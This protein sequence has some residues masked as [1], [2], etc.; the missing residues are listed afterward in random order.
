MGNRP[1]ADLIDDQAPVPATSNAKV[2]KACAA[3]LRLIDDVMRF[4]L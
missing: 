2:P 4:H 3:I 1:A